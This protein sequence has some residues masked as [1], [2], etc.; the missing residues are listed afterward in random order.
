M[1]SPDVATR[2]TISASPQTA[3][4]DEPFALTVQGAAPGERVTISSRLVDDAGHAWAASVTYRADRNGRVDVTR[5]APEP[6]G[7]YDGVE[8]MG[9]VW[10]LR[11]DSDEA[12][13]PML[14]RRR[15]DPL[16]L[17]VEART[18]SGATTATTLERQSI[19]AGVRRTEV[20]DSGLVGTLFEPASQNAP[21]VITL[22]GS[23]GGLS[24]SLAALFASRGFATL[25]LG[26]FAMPGLPDELKSIPLEYFETAMKWLDARDGIRGERVGVVGASRGGELALLLGA[27]FPQVGAVV[28]YAPSALVYGGLGRTAGPPGPAWLHRGEAVPYFTSSRPPAPFP[29]KPSGPIPLTPGFL[30][31]LEDK[32]AVERALIPVER[33]KAPV[34]LVSGDADQMWPSSRYADMVMR[35]LREH[36]HAYPDQHLAY[37]DAGHTLNFPYVPTTVLASKHPLT[38]H[39]FAYGGTPQGQARAREDSWPKVLAFLRDAL[40]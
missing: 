13:N 32:D 25:A 14:F 3:L 11:P 2:T 1:K 17:Q 19:A 27:T 38:G 36:G 7:S 6:G 40:R 33:I 34:L 4:V 18:E 31:G 9:L 37:P 15:L 29:E 23:G 8:P 22:S 10:S 26:Y 16:Q 30:K 12:G 35:R 21:A 24:E 20:R 5:D 39:V 28:S